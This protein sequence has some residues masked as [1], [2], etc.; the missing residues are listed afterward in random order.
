MSLGGGLNRAE[1]TFRPSLLSPFLEPILLQH[2]Q[3]P[4]LHCYQQEDRRS[5]IRFQEFVSRS[6]LVPHLLLLTLPLVTL[7]I[8]PED[9]G[10]TR[11]SA[12][13]TLINNFFQ[14]AANV[15]V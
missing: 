5:R 13:I 7:F 3:D 4:L 14:E 2:R 9:T 6:L 10:D 8:T 1:L 15:T 11:E 12:S